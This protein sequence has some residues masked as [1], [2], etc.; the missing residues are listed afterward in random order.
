MGKHRAESPYRPRTAGG[1]VRAEFPTPT[2]RTNAMLD[3]SGLE[4]LD[5]DECL[6]LLAT[7]RVGRI[8]FTARGLPAVQPV[9][10]LYCHDALWFPAQAHTDLFGAAHDGVVAFE[11]DAFDTDL[12]TGWWVSVL[13]RAGAADEC[14]LLLRRP[15]L[16]WRSPAGGQVRCVRISI[17]VVSGRRVT[18]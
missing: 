14:D 8:V 2:R 15:D 5:R 1:I 18:R 12:D 17:E 3:P 6:A 4:I 16:S 13:G 7:A 10:F 11:T 9:K